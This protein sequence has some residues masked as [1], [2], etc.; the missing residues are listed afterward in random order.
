M[1]NKT[2]YRIAECALL[3]GLALLGAAGCSRGATGSAS[4]TVF[5]V[6]TPP[7]STIAA[8]DAAPKSGAPAWCRTVDSPSVTALVNVLPQLVTDKAAGAAPQVHAAATV[9][10]NAA[11]SAP[12]GP[13][14]LLTAAADSL[15]TA[16][17]AKSA[18]SL[19]AVG[20]AF[21]SLSKGVQSTCGFH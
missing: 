15:D 1:T 8:A 4:S 9:L 18:A 12:A 16:A 21:A 5:A 19:Q 11:V 3:A 10:R 6:P 13:K 7:P 17:G 2:Y 20:T 14:R